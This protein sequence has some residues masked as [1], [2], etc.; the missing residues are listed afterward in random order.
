MLPYYAYKKYKKNQALK[1]AALDKKDEQFLAKVVEQPLPTPEPSTPATTVD[2]LF[3]DNK[4]DW[5][6]EK[7]KK[8]EPWGQTLKRWGTFGRANSSSSI[9]KNDSLS[10]TPSNSRPQTPSETPKPPAEEPTAVAANSATPEPEL[11]KEQRDLAEVLDSL[12]MQAGQQ[13][14]AF[15]TP[16][17]RALLQKFTQIIKDVINGVPTAYND[18]IEFF[19]SSSTQLSKEW[20]S[21]PSSFQKL[22]RSL[23]LGIP[24]DVFTAM[25]AAAVPV[26]ASGEQSSTESA[27]KASAGLGSKLNPMSMFT[28]TN[29]KTGAKSATL[30]H[31]GQVKDLL[32]TGGGI[33]TILRSIVTFLKTRFPMLAGTNALMSMGISILMLL[34]W[35]CYKR[36]REVRLQKEAEAAKLEAKDAPE[37]VNDTPNSKPAANPDLK[38][39]LAH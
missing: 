7:E 27:P 2:S 23:P 21:L 3:E 14:I 32:G 12:D 6:K 22:I 34:L 10:P 35:Y 8:S 18:L 28:K 24:P 16:G 26:A 15:T 33:A 36:G 17:T 20:N 29:P 4:S 5:N 31:P 1:E 13:G 30:P 25:T 37:L 19:E 9:S 11:T 39:N 38:G